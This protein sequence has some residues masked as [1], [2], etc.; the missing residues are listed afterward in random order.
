V[1][2]CVDGDLEIGKY[3]QQHVKSKIG[4]SD[5]EKIKKLSTPKYCFYLPVVKFFVC[6]I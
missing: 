1:L 6:F 4:T 3:Q 5:L 2:E